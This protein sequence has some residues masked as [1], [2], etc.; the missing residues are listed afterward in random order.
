[1]FYSLL[2]GAITF[3]GIYEIGSLLAN[4]KGALDGSTPEMMNHLL[5]G[6]F[7]AYLV[8]RGLWLTI[9]YRLR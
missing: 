4:N 1:M 6:A 3:F 5:W 2:F 7:L 8:V 9:V